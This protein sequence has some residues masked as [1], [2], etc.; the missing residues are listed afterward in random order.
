MLAIA[1]GA[2]LAASSVY[3]WPEAVVISDAVN[4]PLFEGFDTRNVRS[5][6]VE[7]FNEDRNEVERLLVRRKG[8]EWVLP[9]HSN[10]VADNGRQLGAV[11]NL[12]VDMTVLEKRSDNQEDH[13]KYGVVDPADAASAVNRSNLGKK[14][15]LSDRNNKELASLIVGLPLKNDPKQLKHYVRVPGQPSVY[16][17]EIDPRGLN[18]EFTA[19]VSPNL[20]KLSQSTRLKDITVDSYRLDP[21]NMESMPRD[22]SYRSQ[23]IIGDQKFE[24]ELQTANEDGKL[25]ETEPSDAQKQAIQQAAGSI[26]AIPF[27]GVVTKNKLATKSL[28]K[29]N[30]ASKKDAFD[31]LKQ[32]GF[33]VT[34]FADETWQFD[35]VGGSVKVRTAD[36]VVITLHI[37]SID[38]QTRNNSLKLNHNLMLVAGVDESLFPEPEKPDGAE[39]DS[40]D[41]DTQKAYLRK[42]AE[43]TKQLKIGRQR[44]AALNESFSKWYYIVSEDTVAR[45][46]P[47]LKGGT[48]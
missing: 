3:P 29:Q 43:R 14:I 13:L 4:K 41:K 24:I 48:P 26:A 42:L 37:G 33:Q 7:T 6:R 2:A 25:Q 5:I 27:N 17:V 35:S 1:A 34:E 9:T 46:R 45:L 23:L 19:W 38:N 16:V 47:E 21:E 31:S 15:S 28:R 12:L 44:A 8:E 20:L 36:G 39:D 10:F 32:R 18:P 11:V 22:A 40:D 30:A